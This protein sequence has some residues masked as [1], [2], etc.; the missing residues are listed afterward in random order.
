M[1][2]VTPNNLLLFEKS[3]SQLKTYVE[4]ENFMGY[5]PYDTLNSPIPFKYFGK[6]IPV[7][8]LQFQKRNPL[9]IRSLLGIKKEHNPKGLGLFLYAYCKL[10]KEFPDDKQTKQIEYLFNQ[11]KNKASK[12]YSGYCWGYNFD[13]AS[14][15]KYIK[16]YSPNIVVTAFIAKGIFEYYR[17]TQNKEAVDILKSIC[18]FILNDL[19]VTE[20]SEGLCI[21]YTTLGVDNCYNASLLAAVVLAQV[22]SITNEEQLKVVALKAVDFVVC[23]Q[24]ADGHWNYSIDDQGKERVQIDFHQG[25]VIDCIDDVMIHCSIENQK[26]AESIKKGTEYYHKQQFF[27]NGQ[28]KWRLP[29]IYPV[30]IHNQSQGIIT[31]VKQRHL[32]SEYLRFSQIIA[33]WTIDEMQSKK[34]FF[35]YRKLKTYSNKIPFMRW[36]QAW[37]FVALTELIITLKKDKQDA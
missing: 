21:S 23:K 31:F 13:W 5:D 25:Y 2:P 11:L 37:M 16:A 36:S 32:N 4:K 6:L 1:N 10:Q 12:G 26:Y 34:G 30:E 9:N 14:S 24:H 17:L 29:K 35:Y 7:L 15:G 18:K 22:Y 33:K 27:E 8:A 3:F 20:T 28:S 19:P